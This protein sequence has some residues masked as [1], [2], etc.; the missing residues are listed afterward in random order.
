[1]TSKN[2]LASLFAAYL[3]LSASSVL[4]EIQ[5]YSGEVRT[6]VNDG[7]NDI[8]SMYG[9]TLVVDTST[10]Y[11]GTFDML[12]SDV[13]ILGE[14]KIV[15]KG[16]GKITIN[17]LR[18]LAGPYPV[19]FYS[20]TDGNTAWNKHVYADAITSAVGPD[21][22]YDQVNVSPTN[23]IT[24]GGN[25]GT[26]TKWLSSTKEIVATISPSSYTYWDGSDSTADDN[27]DGGTGTWNS[28]N[29]N[30]TIDGGAANS[31]WAG[32]TATATF[33]TTGGTVTVNGTQ[34][35]GG[36][37]FEANG[38]TLSA[39]TSPSLSL[40]QDSTITVNT[41][42]STDTATIVPPLTGSFGI[43]KSGS[44]IAILRGTNTYTGT[45]TVTAGTLQV[46]NGGTTGSLGTGSI[47]NNGTLA[48]NFGTSTR[49][50]LPSSTY[51]GTG[52]LTVNS[53]SAL[54]SGNLSIGGVLTFNTTSGG[55]TTGTTPTCT[56]ATVTAASASLSGYLY[57]DGVNSKTLT[58]D[59]S[60]STSTGT[61][62]VSGI[63]SGS[64][65][66]TTSYNNLTFN[67]GT[68][69][70][71]ITGT[72]T[73]H[74]WSSGATYTFSGALQGNGNLGLGSQVSGTPSLVLNA[75]ATSSLS[76]VISGAQTLT[77]GGSGTLT[78]SGAN[79]Y[80]GVTASNPGTSVTAGKLILTN[81]Y[82]SPAF[83]IASG[84][85]LELNNS[86]TT[87][88]NYGT[89]TKFTGTGILA[90]TGTGT[91]LWG[92]SA[93]TFAL[94][95][96]SKIDVQQGIFV[97]GSNANEVWT[98]NKSALNVE[99]GASFYTVEAT[100]NVDALT[101]GGTVYSAYNTGVAANANS[102]LVVGIANGSG[103]F[104]GTIV[105]GQ[106]ITTINAASTK[107]LT[108]T[109]SGT[110]TL[111][112]ANTYIGTTTITGG[113]LQIAGTNGSLGNGTYA[114]TITLSNSS[115]LKYSS[116]VAQI[117]SGKITGAGNL[118]KDT[119]ANSELTLS[120]ANDYSGTTTVNKGTLT[121]GANSGVP[122]ASAVTVDLGATLKV[123]SKAVTRGT[124][125]TV[126]GTLDLGTNGTVLLDTN[127]G[128]HT[129]AAI[130]G[131]G[132]IT[133]NTG[134]TLVL[135]AT[136]VNTGVNI[137]L[138]GGTLKIAETSTAT[139]TSIGTLKQ[140]AAS[141]LDLGTSTTNF[142]KLKVASLDPGSLL[143]TVSNWTS[144][145]D[146]F[147][148]TAINNTTARNLPNQGQLGYIQLGTNSANQTY[149]A[150][151]ASNDEL[152]VGSFSYTYWDG[153]GNGTAN[154]IVEGGGGTWNSTNTNWTISGG[155]ANATWAGGS[156]VPIFAG[157]TSGAV[158]V[159]SAQSIG[160][161]TFSASN[162][163]GTYS[164]SGSTLTGNASNNILTADT[165]VT[166]SVANVLAGGSS[167]NT[168]EKQGDGT[169]ILTGTN[170]YGG[171]TTVTKG[172]LQY[173]NG[174]ANVGIG[175]TSGISI[176]SSGTLSFNAAANY[177]DLSS[178]SK[179]IT[180]AG[181]WVLT[182]STLSNTSGLSWSANG[183][184]IS[185]ALPDTF[186]GT[187]QI[188]KGRA[189]TDSSAKGLGGT[190]S[191]IVQNGAQ[192]GIF[193]GS[194]SYSPSISLAGTGYGTSAWDTAAIRGADNGVTSTLT[195]LVTLTGDATVGAA[196]GGNLVFSNAI[197]GAYALITGTS[198]L[199][200]TVTLKGT[201]TYSG[202]TTI[203]YGILQVTDSGTLG[204][205]SYA[206]KIINNSAFKYSS[207]ANQTLSGVLSG[208]GSY[209]K[210]TSSSSTLM[211]TGLNTYTGSTTI[212]AGT[213]QIGSAGALG[214]SS[215]TSTGSYAGT[216]SNAG[217]LQ[218][219]SSVDQTLSGV[220]SGSGALLKDT[221]GSS[222]LT[223][224]ARNTYSGTTTVN[225]G[226]LTINPPDD[227]YNT[228]GVASTQFNVGAG[229]TL[230][231]TGGSNRLNLGYTGATTMALG[232]GGTVDFKGAGM[233]G[234]NT[235]TFSSSG[236]TATIK[237]SAG[238]GVNLNNQSFVFDTAT[239]S[240]L[241][242]SISFGNSTGTF[243]KKGAGTAVTSANLNYSGATTISG[244]T[245]QLSGSSLLNLGSYGGSITFSNSS[246]LQYSSS[247]AQTLSGKITGAGA[248][249]K[250]TSTSVLTLSG[251][252]DYTGT[253]TVKAG[254]VK[255]D[256]A[257]GVSADSAVTVDAG[258]TLS[259]NYQAATRNTTTTVNG[260]LSLAG[261]SLTFAANS[262]SH[263]IAT[264]DSSGTTTST[265][266]I[267]NGATVTLNAKTGTGTTTITVNTG[268]TLVLSGGINTSTLNITLAG[269]TLKI[270]DGITVSLGTLSQTAASTIDMGSSTTSFVS[271]TA[272][273]LTPSTYT[274]TVS[275]WTSGSDHFYAT[276][277]TGNPSKNTLNVAPL[278]V[279]TLGSNLAS[280]TYWASSTELLAGSSAGYTYW[281]GPA[282]NTTSIEGGAG[283][284]NSTNSNWTDSNGTINGTWAGGTN[285]ANFKTTG[286]TVTVN[287]TQSIGG[288]NFEA[289]GYTLSAG[290]SPSLSL[291][292][293]STITVNTG[294][295]TDTAT[296]VPPLTGSFGITK[297]GSGIAILRG[298]NTYTGA[299]TVSEG[300]LQFGDG[301]AN[302]GIGSTSGISIASGA[303]LRF[304]YAS[305]VAL[306]WSSFTGAGTL[307]INVP[308]NASSVSWGQTSSPPPTTLPSGFTGTL[309]VEYGRVLATSG[310]LGGTTSLILPNG[311]QFFPFSTASG[312]VTFT[313]AISMAGTGH[314][315]AGYESVI[316]ANGSSVTSN[317][318][319]AVTLTG[320]ATVAA[321]DSSTLLFSNSVS[322]AYALLAGTSSAKGTVSLNGTNT[323]TGDTT[324]SY[325]TL[326]VGGA[327]TLGSGSYAGKIINN[328]GST[329]K[330]SSSA[331]QTLSGVLSGAGS[332]TKDTSS[333]STLTLTGTNTYTG[334]TTISAGTLQ[335][336]GS[337][338]LGSGTYAGAITDNGTLKY[339]SSAAQTLSGTISGTG[340]L[341]KDTSTST[342]TLKASNSYSGGTTVSAGTLKAASSTEG[343]TS[344]TASSLG[345]GAIVVESS[346]TLQGDTVNNP[347]GCSYYGYGPSQITIRG[348][349]TMTTGLNAWMPTLILDGGTLS[350]GATGTGGAS[351]WMG[352]NVSVTNNSTINALGL[353]NVKTGGVTYNVSSGKTLSV[354]SAFVG[355]VNS[356][357]SKGMTLDGGGTMVLSGLNTDNT[358]ITINSGTLQI[359]GSGALGWG[360]TT[361]N[362]TGA[363][364]NK[365]TLQYSSSATQTLTG[366][367]TG[368]GSL[369][370]DTNT[371]VLTLSG[372]NDYTGT[373]TVNT[374]TLTYGADSGV[375]GASAVTV[376]SGATLNVNSKAATRTATT[377][378]N[379][380][381]ALGTSGSVTFA[382]NSGSHTI[383][384]ITGSGTIT[385]NSGA[386]VTLSGPI[387]NT[388]VNFTLAGGTLKITGN[389]TTSTSLGTLTVSSAST[390]DMD[391]STSN[392]ANVTFADTSISAALTVSNW[393]SGSDHLYATKM[394]GSTTS[395]AKNTLNVTPLNYITLGSNSPSQT[396]W[397]SSTELLVGS[398]AGYTYWDGPV[399]NTT[400]I[401]GGKGNWTSSNT[402]WTTSA[403]TPNSTWSGGT[404]TANFTVTGDTVTVSGTQSIGGLNFEVTG[405]SLTNG[406]SPSLSLAQDSTINVTTGTA[407]VAPPL[408]GSFGITKSGTGV[409]ILN[410]ANTYTGTTTVSAGTL[411]LGG[412][413]YNG[414]TFTVGSSGTL[415]LDNTDIFGSDGTSP[416][417]TFNISGTLASNSSYNKL[418]ILNLTGG[419]LACNGGKDSSWGCF[420]LA[421][422]VT[423][424]GTSQ[425]TTNGSSNSRVFLGNAV[426]STSATTFN[427]SDT[428]T[429][430]APL[431]NNTSLTNGALTKTGTGSMVLTAV[432]T[433][434]GATTISGGTLQISSSGSL[435]SGSYAGNISNA[436]ALQY[437]SSATQ[438]LS[439]VISGAGTLTKDTSTSVLTLS[440][441]NTY[442]GLT[443]VSAGTLA[444]SGTSYNGGTF[445]VDSGATLRLDANNVFGNDGSSPTTTFNISGTL[446]SNSTYTKLNTLNLTGAT[447]ACN[448]GQDAYWGCFGLAGNVTTSGTSQ[449]TTNAASNS[450][451]FL[452]NAVTSTAATTFNVTDTFTVGAPLANNASLA[453]SALT[454]TGSGT[455]ALTAVNTYTGATTISGGTL[456]ISGTGSLGSGSY[457]GA[458]TLSNSSTL[459]YSSSTAQTLSGK[460]SGAGNLIKDT[461]TSA[462]TLSGANDY[463]GTTTVNTGTLTYGSDSGVSG[464][465]AVTV[466]PGA[467]LN[468]NS[469]AATRSATTTING[470]LALGT[471]G[472]VTFAAS[473]GSHTIASL[474]GSG[475]ITINNGATVTLSAKADTNAVTI[476]VNSGGTL[477]V[478]GAIS[479]TSLS[480]TLS[481]GTLQ[482]KDTSNISVS[483]GT[484]KQTADS[485]VDLGSS[486][487]TFVSLTVATLTPDTYNMTVSNWTSGKDHF[488]A[489]NITGNP[490]KNTLNVAPLNVISMGGSSP[491][492]TYWTST[493]NE[494]LVG[495]SG[496]YTYWDG[497]GTTGNGAIE[498]GDGDWTSSKTNWTTSTGASNSTWPGS[499]SIAN[500]TTA[501]GTVTVTGTQSIGGLTFNIS[502]Y[503]I[504]GGTLTGA[505]STNE[506][507]ATTN[508]VTASIGSVLS[509]GNA[510][511]KEGLGTITLS[512][513]NT[514]TGLMYV[515]EG[516][517]YI[518]SANALGAAQF[519]SYSYRTEVAT[520]ATLGVLG[521]ITTAPE[522]L[523]LSGG[524]LE[525]ISGTNTFSGAVSVPSGNAGTILNNSNGTLT[526]TKVWLPGGS[527]TFDGTGAINIS[528]VGSSGGVTKA[529]SGITT[530]S[531]AN[532]YSGTTTISAGTLIA[533]NDSALGAVSKGTTVA[534]G[535]SLALSGNISTSAEPLTLNGTGASSAGALYNASGSNGYAGAIT[536]GSAATI[537]NNV[538]NTTLTASGNVANAGYDL[539]LNNS[540]SIL[541][542][543]IVSGTGKLIKSGNGTATL[544]G[545]TNSYT[546]TTNVNE[547]IL[548]YGDKG[549]IPAG[550]VVTVASLAT[551]SAN[552]I[553]GI[554]RSANTTIDG[555]LDL[556]SGG[557]MTLTAGTHTIKSITGSGTITVNSG[558]TLTLSGSFTNTN[559]NIILAGGSLYVSGGAT[560]S[561]GSLSQTASS[562]MDFSSSGNAI[563]RVSS[564]VLNSLALQV[565]NWT[566]GSDHFYATAF[567]GAAR[568]TIGAAPMNLIT[569]GSTSSAYTV[570]QSSDEITVLVNPRVKIAK[571]SNGGVG[572]FTFALNGLSATTSSII[573]GTP[574]VTVLNPTVYTGTSGQAATIT[575]S[576]APSGWSTIPVSASC[577]DANG[578]T[579]GNGSGAIGT[580]SGSVLTI[581]AAKM[582]AGADFTC[583]FVNQLNG[584]SGYVFNDGGAPDSSNVNSGTPNDG[585][586]NGNEAGISGRTITLSDC[587]STTYGTTTTDGN[588][589][590]GISIPSSVTTGSPLCLSA[591]VPSSYLATGASASGTALPSGTATTV[592]GISYTYTRSSQQVS[593][594][595]PASGTATLNFGMVPIST[596]TGNAAQQGIAGGS[597][598]YAHTFTAGTGGSVSFSS[599]NTSTPSI[600]GWNNVLYTDSGCTGTRQSS[601]TL[602]NGPVTV[603]QGQVYCFISQVSIPAGAANGNSNVTG[604]TASLGFTNASP[605]LSASYSNTDTTTVGSSA[606]SL[607]KEV[608]NV[609]TNG[610]W[611]TSNKAKSGDVLE[612]KITYTNNSAS[613]MTSV[614]ISDNTP[615]Y[616]T[617][618]SAT[619]GSTPTALGSCTKK[620]PT[621]TAGSTCSS[622]DTAGGTGTVEWAFSGKLDPG[623][624]SYVLFQVK[625]E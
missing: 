613:P 33:K 18:F 40:A 444:L 37:N 371:S 587:G 567:A 10:E 482:I 571:Q 377:T 56:D 275:N 581:P 288:L 498:G 474:S 598:S 133:V 267:N 164:L 276:A 280:Q 623:E 208:A 454:K 170:T 290:T 130:N 296:I 463:T 396:Y 485:T 608:R 8:I 205:G 34:S 481:G 416:A 455:M 372:A 451:V 104:S 111:T 595:A 195:G 544:S 251:S 13:R 153:G 586:K 301:S 423:T 572:D 494:L 235:L 174:S 350:S 152:L 72:N 218:Y 395:P 503:S 361:G 583:T 418:N 502:G 465:S 146:H 360:G 259:V 6:K 2:I 252:N 31:I 207:S 20:E 29:T 98:D 117:L 356:D 123:N 358:A 368:V 422:A 610:N 593:F 159:A 108:K 105:D 529:G 224:T 213:L 518:S 559:V 411:A 609:T 255:Y 292:Q 232:N 370:K 168:F 219:S 452:G 375:S 260:T 64:P 160:G 575:E 538:S 89:T 281:D 329:F 58:I 573:T 5:V 565:N 88:R 271:L 319:G 25:S 43:T 475:T 406:T 549:G 510:F 93:A 562:I 536:L 179:L 381:L 122:S 563:L 348:T 139:A 187:L 161:L 61:L 282:S 110:Q 78:L 14:C 212:G 540:A 165:G 556:G 548:S 248:L 112:G 515:N 382:A 51:S 446:A 132:T 284:W 621:N 223:L 297:S 558:A 524:T 362:Y 120:G 1:L 555:T 310:G 217:T 73:F 499:S 96:N 432:N 338:S 79:T 566:N 293:D 602:I 380:T 330:Y 169:V 57:C 364:T 478:D 90:K 513:N 312:T 106:L 588:G 337:G 102:G 528:L 107:S 539:T 311:S 551:L 245:L 247:G 554:T 204:S 394:G 303:K 83:D 175:S 611:G 597:V 457:G 325:G 378:I 86:T 582:I 121:Y 461:N 467:T 493:N 426:T 523:Y 201:N 188:E 77:K 616:T 226:T 243:T 335:V 328:S 52:N 283:T 561:V 87:D 308:S 278:N 620:T 148:A 101:G 391:S 604:I 404:A 127:S 447:L 402:N 460:I 145:S 137:T 405:Y 352:G 492:L 273:T 439:G 533:A 441:A 11:G 144:G 568:N 163:P 176:A 141:T 263:T 590:W 239:G 331:N 154:S 262:G 294:T 177:Y 605:S 323:Y 417:T 15:I 178:I 185:L 374:G 569:M 62:A 158:S 256:S 336:G 4:A 363:I 599:T 385:I 603:V 477:I 229:A 484:L 419:S 365:G 134:A 496:G 138:A 445:N 534:S 421:G 258:A 438:T 82:A 24:L 407:T 334:A 488:F 166:A 172:T 415:R 624:T 298:T 124:T 211:L 413:S 369:I 222:T 412:T 300:T 433:Y 230:M 116:S 519:D 448:G 386:T 596:L 131:S 184:S 546:G 307:A 342:L 489:S 231:F 194:G 376:D 60:A 531:G 517:L 240:T 584:L 80:N 12:L 55:A 103:T 216:I 182:S 242:N 70:L 585:I 249:L 521:N 167:S 427:V 143:L 200:G 21:G 149:W 196:S 44:G 99:S 612:Y 594:T 464:G 180:G 9:G 84:A 244:G 157:A 340:S 545:A 428:F 314:G 272:A 468:V 393:T 383:A 357:T 345:T 309:S 150:D 66:I 379:G 462:L 543:G 254:T 450:R 264:L 181:K 339:S 547:G 625:V 27:V 233:V 68:N 236:A 392:F 384:N 75:N 506:L 509:G 49:I 511:S 237:S 541:I 135:S 36:L 32:G 203:N 579:N 387:S 74:N 316:R 399:A 317:L 279:I 50:A 19:H 508:A 69:A 420:G 63:T 359:S 215:G 373:T 552:S 390:L 162:T 109:G 47:V 429:V 291:A 443:T 140:T 456:Q 53:G 570:W 367:I 305:A 250:D 617:F 265:M 228:Y 347:F 516:A 440:G 354:S 532:T 490:S 304:N 469:K 38:Y 466:D 476:V 410:G 322:G 542:S 388:G 614:V 85:T 431:A 16:S 274:M 299:T 458:I 535:A 118:I 578:S 401:E 495:A 366:K 525:N 246:T 346:G 286:G 592:G 397:A 92:S 287:G 285:V 115:T 486:T 142:A 343:C 471:N 94:S 210:D 403:G 470:T 472:T 65:G 48:Y 522:T 306:P 113:T 238:T 193:L 577:L 514:F 114:N 601:A 71:N 23:V 560:V 520:D 261:G 442:T 192:L 318:S 564:L 436:G 3:C 618:Q 46:G 155:T 619:A 269:G 41:G 600:A 351:Y 497:P 332:Y 67:A 190:T 527:I 326:Q 129:I 22:V 553:K 191:V 355:S 414:G 500:F 147:Y 45:T 125:T 324:V 483:L 459:K 501:G 437:S 530:F 189:F 199:T 622:S 473:S 54:F 268:G 17:I 353:L 220:I 171:A 42:T 136:I 606:L 28:T 289:N 589:A 126:N 349:V 128:T 35:I 97:G 504:T 214:W 202:D 59:T 76:G 206:G 95:A 313:P 398:T 341:I 100:V 186:T 119:D 241:T 320:N 81:T 7:G 576:G 400:S 277:I 607:V 491:T 26:Q 39:G 574:G 295:S 257:S 225:A 557:A 449:V 227:S 453:N 151:S 550:S 507:R 321:D 430:G 615:G 91:V 408:T 537:A 302:V 580:L 505:A 389:N 333:S 424:S 253:T 315:E 479:G 435:G 266:S 234:M 156:A 221:S 197:S 270:T 409:A 434:T 591:S 173:G 183:S 209:T 30:W 327:G 344:N 480:V 487:S 512:G 526:V 198:N 425:V